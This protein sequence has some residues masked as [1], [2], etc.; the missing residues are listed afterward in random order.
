ML[1]EYGRALVDL[2]SLFCTPHTLSQKSLEHSLN[3]YFHALLKYMQKTPLFLACRSG[4]LDAA[5]ELMYNGA[6]VRAEDDTKMNCLDAAVENG[7][8]YVQILHH[9]HTACYVVL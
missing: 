5:T 2:Q 1:K 3:E 7:H 4:H 8:E 9:I 6:N